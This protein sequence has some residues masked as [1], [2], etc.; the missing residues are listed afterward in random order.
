MAETFRELLAGHDSP[1]LATRMRHKSGSWRWIEVRACNELANPTRGTVVV[2]VRDVTAE[3]AA[4]QGAMPER[5]PARAKVLVDNAAGLLLAFD[6]AGWDR[7]SKV[8]LRD[9]TGAI[10]GL[11]GVSRDVTDIHREEKALRV[12]RDLLQAILDT[13]PSHIF[14]KDAAG[15]YLRLNRPAA[16]AAGL[17][18]PA[19]AIGKRP[20]ELWP[21]VVADLVRRE[22]EAILATRRP[23]VDQQETRPGPDGLPRTYLYTKVPLVDADG[24]IAGI[25]SV[26]SDITALKEPERRVAEALAKERATTA[27]LERVSAAKSSFVSMVSHEFRT[28]LTAIQGYADLIAEYPLSEAEVREYAGEVV[29]AAERLARMT[30][31]VLALDRLQARGL[32]LDLAPTDLNRVADDVVNLLRPSAPR[33]A[34][35]LAL[36]PDLPIVLADA[37][38]LAQVVTNLVGNAIKYAPAGGTITLTTRRLEDRVRL[39]VR[40]EGVG[41]APDMLERIFEPYVRI[42]A[43]GQA[44]T[45]SGLGLPIARHLVALHGG[46]LW[47]E[48]EPGRGST[49][50]V[51]LPIGGPGGET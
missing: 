48:R 2:S 39:L 40:D 17:D 32:T 1:P 29:R 26:E 25:V 7:E 43:A 3:R 30:A 12:E 14:L 23:L 16:L 10:V 5:E 34:F 11:V 24:R 42:R 38:R 51:E 33:H 19:A 13:I 50:V 27:E 28:P 8:P 35:A 22:D 36:D 21:A 15:R 41:I 37:D 44:V 18:D 9:E 47:A 4:A 49:F 46:R 6:A 31:D 20:D 45:G